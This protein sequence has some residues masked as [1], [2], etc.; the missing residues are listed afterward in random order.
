MRPAESASARQLCGS[1][2]SIRANA[3]ARAAFLEGLAVNG[4]DDA[5]SGVEVDGV[6]ATG[7]TVVSVEPA[8]KGES[9]GVFGERSGVEIGVTGESIIVAQ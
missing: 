1:T 4:R 3:A 9:R 2:A 7:V 8:E 5:E 6:V